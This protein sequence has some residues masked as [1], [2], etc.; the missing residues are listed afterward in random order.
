M[1]LVQALVAA[2]A[3][4]LVAAPNAAAFRFTD[5]AR[6]LP[7]GVVGQPFSHALE[8]VGGCKGVRMQVDAGSLPP[9]L[10][11]VGDVRELVD[12]SN[13]RIEGTPTAAGVFSFWL[14]A[15]NLCPA[16]STEEEFTIRV[17]PTATPPTAA[18]AIS[19]PALPTAV[20]GAPY[21]A[22]LEAAGGG[23]QAWTLTAGTLPAGLSLAAD[24]IVAGTPA[25]GAR[26]S[27][28][29]VAVADAAGRRATRAFTL[30]V[31][32]A[33]AARP[34][35]IMTT[36]LATLRRGRD[37]VVALRTSGG[38]PILRHGVRT[39]RW[40]VVRGRLPVGLRLNTLHGKLI[41]RPR[42]VGRFRIV[43]RATDASGTAAQRTL[44]LTVRR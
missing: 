18:L 21:A 44:V 36:R 37:Y 15:R 16:D 42:Q 7:A 9:G 32:T 31:D 30:T 39:L 20:V 11:L 17:V 12:G 33:P 1:R 26:T 38:T 28:F 22:R 14:R 19:T 27:S 24:G 40:K 2:G 8:T 23:A 41:G 29:T 25:P 4:A 35:A 43:V 5:D 6:I 13:W 34:L 3:L 10:R